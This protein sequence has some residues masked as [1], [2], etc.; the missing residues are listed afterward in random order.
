MQPDLAAVAEKNPPAP[1]QQHGELRQRRRR[2]DRDAPA[3]QLV[4]F[5]LLFVVDDGF[6]WFLL[7]CGC[8]LVRFG[9][10]YMF[11]FRLL[12]Q[13]RFEWSAGRAE[14]RRVT[15]WTFFPG[16]MPF[17]AGLLREGGEN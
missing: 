7:L 10:K 11:R 6:G 15:A 14:I 16:G 3:L 1:L 4:L 13:E 12:L 5:C 2:I 9:F 17:F 8:W